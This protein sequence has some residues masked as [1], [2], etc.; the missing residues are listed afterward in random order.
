VSVRMVLAAAAALLAAVSQAASAAEGPRPMKIGVVNVDKVLTQGYKKGKDLSD[1]IGEDFKVLEEA[2]KKKAEMIQADQRKLADGGQGDSLEFLR[3]KQT[4][5]LRIAE[6]RADE[7][8]FL[9]DRNAAELKAMGELW[10]DFNAA[11]AKIAKDKGMDLVLQQQVLDKEDV[12]TKTSFVR[13]AASC[14]VLYR[15]DYLDI[16]DEL[17]QALNADYERSG[18]PAPTPKG[19]KKN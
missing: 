11:V 10:A 4:I 19:G 6:L 5:E 7:K 17:I 8:K 14:A 9:G 1:K 3:A 13:S 2:L 18:A 12:K 15:A 16:T